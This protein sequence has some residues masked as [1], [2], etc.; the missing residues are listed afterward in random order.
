MSDSKTFHISESDVDKKFEL[1]LKNCHRCKG[2]EEREILTKAYNFAKIAH[3]GQ[4]RYNG[5]VFINHPVEVAKIVTLDIG[6]STTSAVAALL[7][8][9]ITNTEHDLEDI[10]L[11]LGKEITTLVESLAKIKGTSNFFNINKSEVYKRLLLGISE[12]IR[13]IYIKIADR[14]HNMRTLD[15]L[16]PEK[17]LKVANETMYVYAPLAER[18]G[19]FKIKSELEDLAFK[20]LQPNNY[21]DIAKRIIDNAQ[22]NTMYLNRFALP[23]IAK[24][25][26]EKVNFNIISRQKSIYSIWK[27][28]KRKKIGFNE[29]Y[30]I[31]AIRL[32]IEP[33]ESAEEKQEV[34]RVYNLL[35]DMY[36][37]KE[38]RVRNWIDAPK[39][40]GYEALHVTVRGTQDRWVEIQIRSTRMDDIAEHGFASH[41]KYKGLEYQKVK[42]DEKIKKLKNQFESIEEND[43]DY[44]S[45]F[46]L[47]FST[48]IVSYTPKG[49][50][51]ILPVGSSVL[52][53]AFE[54]HSN[55]GFKCIG[56]KVNNVLVP[57][58]HKIQSG[59][60]IHIL[61]SNSQE[62][63]T[64]WL[65]TVKTE[66]AKAKLNEFFK[67]INISEKEQGQNTLSELLEKHDII[68]S[69]EL[70]KSLINNF[71]TTNKHNLYLQIGAEEIS[72]EKL[73]SFIK[74]QSKWKIRNFFSPAPAQK[75]KLEKLTNYTTAKCCNPIPGDEI[76]GIKNYNEIVIHRS[77]C[78]LLK[79]KELAKKEKIQ[80]TWKSYKAK[81]FYTRL[82]LEAD[83]K[84]GLFHQISRALANDLEVNI[85]SIHF[86]TIDNGFGMAGWL[87]IYVLNQEHLNQIILKLKEVDGVTKVE[88]LIEL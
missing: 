65:N 15:S 4:T 3:K 8:D 82:E 84:M 19:L 45:N 88:R 16:E 42:F 83:N 24:L 85:K 26:K 17:K 72:I 71:K 68:P 37:V 60:Y 35:R 7:H 20:Y 41:W 53:F 32:I 22:K 18:L 52:D 28:I 51:I 25:F 2:Q 66:K 43:F 70:F 55:L 76:I 30:D 87:E 1:F 62:P 48:E 69:P 78:S 12:D 57:L 29:V 21:F 11:I 50:E 13:I 67:K 49:K 23:I 86:D 81:S 80:I 63:K 27:K 64:D 10:R 34:F 9:T 33:K 46:K 6:L 47:L 40:N 73:E 39:D 58:D 31:F 77:E 74:K 44:L 56:A 61:T 36:E 38:D 79:N 14:L 75:S 59:D 5:D 54:I